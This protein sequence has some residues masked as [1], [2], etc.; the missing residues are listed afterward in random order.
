MAQAQINQPE[1]P[2]VLLQQPQ[3]PAAVPVPQNQPVNSQPVAGN[4]L[5]PPNLGTGRFFDFTLLKKES[6]GAVT[7]LPRYYGN[8]PVPR[9]DLI[10]G[11]QW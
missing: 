6:A 11:T 2:E 5:D 9:K 3:A 4:A 7:R 10:F 8:R 1:S